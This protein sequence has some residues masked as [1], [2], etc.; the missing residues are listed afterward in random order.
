MSDE[1]ENNEQNQNL[2]PGNDDGAN[3]SSGAN[4]PELSL[5]SV[6]E[7]DDSELDSFLANNGRMNLQDESFESIQDNDDPDANAPDP[8]ENLGDP[9]DEDEGDPDGDDPDSELELDANEAMKMIFAPFKANGR[10]MQ[11]TSPEEV[12]RLMQQ[13]AN[14]SKNMAEFAPFKKAMKLL[15]KRQALDPAR[16]DFLL[17]VAEGKPEAIAKLLSE[18]QIDPYDI[19][20]D[21]GKDYVSQYEDEAEDT[22]SPV[23]AMLDT[24]PQM[25]RDILLDALTHPENAWDKQSRAQIIKY[26]PQAIPMLSK[27]IMNG[28][29][30]T[31]MKVLNTKRALGEYAG[32]TDLEAYNMVGEELSKQGKLGVPST[33][34]ESTNQNRPNKQ[35]N[36]A[37]IDAQRRKAG[38]APRQVPSNVQKQAVFNPA[39]ATEEELDAFIQNHL[40]TSAS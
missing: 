32:I 10:E 38:A 30:A 4:A 5:A 14:Y 15:E 16:L 35:K 31:I 23:M 37:D 36:G 20:V 24:V 28:Q 13:G 12:V 33:P 3:D 21:S 9:D 39:T 1:L 2:E 25:S 29:F 6:H 34:N 27:Q 17:D 18:H 7:M 22:A 26:A 19:N 11:V 40:R 8:D